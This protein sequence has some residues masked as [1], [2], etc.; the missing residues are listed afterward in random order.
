MSVL[1]MRRCLSN[2]KSVALTIFELLAFNPPPPNLG[3]MW[4]WPRPL[5]EKKI[6]GHV[7]IVPEKL[8]V[9]FEVCSFNHFEAIGI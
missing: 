9:K 8:Y 5:F 1:S 2:L 6:G 7:H 3:D 4:T